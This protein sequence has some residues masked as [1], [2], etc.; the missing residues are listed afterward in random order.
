[1]TLLSAGSLLDASWNQFL[2]VGDVVSWATIP[3]RPAGVAV[4]VGVGVGDAVAVAVGVAVGVGV[5][6]GVPALSTMT[7]PVISGCV[8]QTNVYVPG[9]GKLQLP[10]QPTGCAK[11]GIGGALSGSRNGTAVAV[12]V[13]GHSVGFGLF[14]KVTLWLLVPLPWGTRT[15]PSHRP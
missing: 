4:A 11:P 1:M 12:L 6:V 10:S 14:G 3:A 9:V 13:C 5:G 15:S 7:V 8:E 2:V